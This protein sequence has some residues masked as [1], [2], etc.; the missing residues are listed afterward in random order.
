MDDSILEFIGEPSLCAYE[1]NDR[2][3]FYKIEDYD[4]DTYLNG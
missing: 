3:R 4:W 1:K 2:G